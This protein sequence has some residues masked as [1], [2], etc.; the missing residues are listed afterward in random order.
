MVSPGDWSVSIN[1]TDVYFHVPINQE[2]QH[3]PHL[4]VSLTGACQF[5]PPPFGLSPALQ[6]FV[7]V[8]R[9]VAQYIYH[10][11]IKF[12]FYLND[13]LICHHDPAIWVKHLTYV[14][15]FAMHLWWL[16]NLKKSNLVASQQLIYLG[17]DFVMHLA[18]IRP[19][20]KCVERLEACICLLLQQPCQLACWAKWSVWE[21]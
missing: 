4:V 11:G 2:H 6:I 3:F 17:L 9:E 16:V 8:L 14:L 10:H 12:H 5:V 20:L 7:M 1:L 13:W 21:M 19:S 18:L 15:D